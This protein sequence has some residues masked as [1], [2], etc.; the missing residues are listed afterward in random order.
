MVKDEQ[1]AGIRVA[2]MVAG[3]ARWRYDEKQREKIDPFNTLLEKK[4]IVVVT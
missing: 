4:I 3:L 2:D 1:Y